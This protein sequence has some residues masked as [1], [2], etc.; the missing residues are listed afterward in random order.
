MGDPMFTQSQFV[1]K[2]QQG[3][4]GPGNNM[5]MSSNA[6]GMGGSQNTGGFGS[7]NAQSNYIGAN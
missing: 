7:V 3:G 4:G 5:G 1:N 6:G 2:P